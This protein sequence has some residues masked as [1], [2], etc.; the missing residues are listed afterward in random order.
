MD[1]TTMYSQVEV[2]QIASNQASTVFGA[3]KTM[4]VGQKNTTTIYRMLFKFP[5]LSIPNHCI[6]SKALLKIYVQFAANSNMSLYTPFALT[7]DWS[8]QTVNWLNQPSFD[9]LISGETKSM[10]TGGFYTFNI[11]DLISKWYNNQIPNYGFLLKNEELQDLTYNQI[12]TIPNPVSS[13]IV[14]ISYSPLPTRF[15]ENTEEIDTDENCS[16]SSIADISFTKTI[17]CQIENLGDTSVE[18]LFQTSPDGI[19]FVC[20]CVEASILLPHE[21]IWKT[22]YSFAKFGRVAAKNI[23][24]GE[25]SR[26]KI[27]YQAQ[28]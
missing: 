11:T 20:D 14:E 8:V 24:S 17:T 21:K 16:F 19:N 3:C 9:P 22:P 10:P 28:E 26:I 12:V 7:N 15:I 18:V 27:W 5:I 6:I 4:Y 25:T 1:S 13:P 2:A 23:N